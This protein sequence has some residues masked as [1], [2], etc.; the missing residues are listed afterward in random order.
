MLVYQRVFPNVFSYSF[1]MTSHGFMV[2]SQ[3]PELQMLQVSRKNAAATQGEQ[4][5]Q[6]GHPWIYAV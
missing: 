1:L 4:H 2:T 6:W 3:P 5:D